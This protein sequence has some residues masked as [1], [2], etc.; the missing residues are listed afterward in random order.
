[1][2]VRRRAKEERRKRK[3]AEK[4]S[5]PELHIGYHVVA[6]LDIMGYRSALMT[7][8]RRPPLPAEGTTECNALLGSVK[9]VV[10]IRRELVRLL[11][12]FMSG[13]AIG[14]ST[15][16]TPPYPP[17]LEAIAQTW[18][19]FHIGTTAFS[20]S[21]ILNVSLKPTQDHVSVMRALLTM[22][23]A[24]ASTMLQQ[25]ARGGD[26]FN[27]TLPLRGAIDC[28]VS[29]EVEDHPVDGKE[30]PAPQLYSAALARAADQ[31]KKATVPR[32]VVTDRFMGMVDSYADGSPTTFTEQADKY[33]AGVLKDLLFEDHF[34][35]T[36]VWAVDFLGK[37]FRQV[38]RRPEYQIMVQRAL[39]FA[40]AA[41]EHWRGARDAGRA[42]GRDVSLE[43]KLAQRYAYLEQYVRSRLHFWE[44]APEETG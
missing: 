16:N 7:L 35:G 13:I 12:A 2:S 43:E 38:A 26:D 19:R 31:E 44:I 24:C 36:K 42:S 32:L 39:Q 18:R 14:S 4:V 28:D 5:D 10:Q 9:R 25:L 15:G 22:V 23:I 33:Q 21:I 34:E 11:H 41:H 8:S 37:G 40:S 27:A 3:T 29:L 20:D 6:L 30:P 1:M 17:R